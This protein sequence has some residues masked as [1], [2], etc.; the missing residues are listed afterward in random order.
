MPRPRLP[1]H[2]AYLGRMSAGVSISGA[3]ALKPRNQQEL[4]RFIQAISDPRSRL[5][6]HYLRRGQYRQLFGPSAAT[7]SATVGV[8]RADG[9]VVSG[10]SSNGLMVFFNGNANRIKTT[11]HVQLGHYRLAQGGAG[12]APMS[13]IQLPSSIAGSV[14]TVVGLDNLVHLKS[15]DPIRPPASMR[16]SFPAART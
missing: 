7:V 10:V 3:V 8:L 11:F 1:F 12:Y 15:A 4:A 9:L 2:T 5:F 16:G 6:H 13:A 14:R